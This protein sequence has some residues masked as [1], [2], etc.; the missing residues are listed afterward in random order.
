MLAAGHEP[1]VFARSFS[2]DAVGVGIVP[3]LAPPCRLCVAFAAAVEEEIRRHELDVVHDNGYGWYCDVFQPTADRGASFEQN[4]LLS[5]LLV[6]SVKRQAARWLTRHDEFRQLVDRQYGD[7]QRIYMP[8]SRMV[9]DHMLRDHGVPADQMRSGL[10]RGR[11][12]A[13]FARTSRYVP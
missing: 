6:R 3:H 5:P 1:H 11:L 12:G 2:P 4:L 8:I 7:R 13:V 9:A 10:Q